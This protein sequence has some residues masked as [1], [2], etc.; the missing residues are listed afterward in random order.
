MVAPDVPADHLDHDRLRRLLGAP[1]LAWLVDRVAERLAAG[2][3]AAEGTAALT[4]PSPE[5]RR[6][7]ERLLGRPPG[8]GRTLTIRLGD[9]EAVLRDARISPDGLAAA[10]TALRGPIPVRHETAAADRAA[11]DSAHEPLERLAAD[12]PE[13]APW[14]HHARATGLLK[15][16]AP[17][18][19]AALGLAGQSARVLSALPHSGTVRSIL[20]AGSVGDAHAL[21]DGRPLSAL[22]LSAIRSLSGLAAAD[23]AHAEGRRAAWA[24]VGVATD[25]LS[26]RVLVLNIP[27]PPGDDSILSRVLRL[28]AADGE[29]MTLTLRQLRGLPAGHADLSGQTVSVCENPAVVSAA[30]D[31]FG[32]ECPPLVCLEG[33]PSVAATRLLRWLLDR[34]VRLRYHGDFDPGGFRI[35]A[36]VFALAARAGMPAAPWRYDSRAYLDAA[37]R[38]LGSPLAEPS[39]PDTPWDPD[40]RHHLETNAVRVEEEQV[41]DA[42]LGDLARGER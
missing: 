41:V 7:A 34:G 27:T 5:Q 33:T 31:A 8:R 29:P 39:S 11:W 6:A 16:H 24:G 40:L 36:Q 4:D 2:I 21:D 10:V 22:V 1:E 19:D 3:P 35:A 17:G 18:P 42:L 20:A 25:D 23:T 37:A 12:R 28:T 30:A 26:S 15:R 38:G 14:L 32:A 13:L 9:V